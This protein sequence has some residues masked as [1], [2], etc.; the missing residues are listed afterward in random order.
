MSERKTKAIKNIEQKME[1]MTPDS[2]RYK[3]LE[4]AKDFKT[5]WIGLGQILYT[6]WKD[7]LYK[8]WGYSEFDAFTSKEIGIQK[9]TA[10]KLLRSYSF[11][12]S[13]EPRYLKKDY[14]EGAGAAQVPTYEAVDVLRRASN[15]KDIGEVD[16]S[17]IKKYVLEDGKGARDVQ[18][19]LTKIIESNVQLEPEEMYQKKRITRLRRLLSLLKSLKEEIRTS[20]D[21]PAKIS[22]QADKLIGM[23]EGEVK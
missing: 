4:S 16:Y 10:L 9:P 21:L 13:S 14:A 2:L 23:I 6:V 7:K 15:N 5:S 20:D 3:V 18:K 11:L 12:E 22:D 8:D 1:E 19:D 17:R